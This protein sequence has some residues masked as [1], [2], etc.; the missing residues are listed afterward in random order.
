MKNLLF[1]AATICSINL[2]IA[3]N[4]SYNQF[5]LEAG[6]GMGVPLSTVSNLSSKFF[7]SFSSYSLGTR[8]MITD[9][10]GVKAQFV[11]DSFKE[12]STEGVNNIRLDLQAHYNL[13]K[14]LEIPYSTNDLMSLFVH[15]GFGTS[16]VESLETDV[17]EKTG[18]FIIGLTPIFRFSDSVSLFADASYVYNLKQHLYYDGKVFSATGDYTTGSHFNMSFGLMVYLGGNKRHAD[19]Y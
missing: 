10:W 4:G 18:S 11:S 8:F 16:F 12:S 7:T 5:S 3:Q 19:W 14:K 6:V 13:G 9:Y 17:R 1:I 15:S 2:S